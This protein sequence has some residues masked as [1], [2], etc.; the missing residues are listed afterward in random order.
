MRI[1][2]DRQGTLWIGT[3][4]GLNQLDKSRGTFTS[5]TRQNG[6]PDN[7]IQSILEDDQGTCGWSR[8][9]A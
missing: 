3:E 8:M 4:N 1:W 6:L 2:E 9:T 5:F 7:K